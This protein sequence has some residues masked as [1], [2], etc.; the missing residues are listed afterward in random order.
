[1][2]QADKMKYIY[3]F[4]MT[5]LS[6]RVMSYILFMILIAGCSPSPKPLSPEDIRDH[7]AMTQEFIDHVHARNWKALSNMY[8]DSAVVMQMNTESIY[9]FW[10]EFPP[11][12]EI[13]FYDDGI[14]GEGNLAYVYGR[15]WLQ[16]DLPDNPVDEGK[17][18]DVRRRQSDGTWKYVAECAN[19][20]LPAI[21]A[22]S[23]PGNTE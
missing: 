3:A 19:T 21:I 13:R 7:E 11:V 12:K 20:S 4:S 2:Q 15:Y 9:E 22:N 14:F 23:N 5:M 17:Y 6:H 10:S 16:F 1:M 18:L 8:E